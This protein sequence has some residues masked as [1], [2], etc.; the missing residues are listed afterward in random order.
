VLSEQFLE[1]L[2]FKSEIVEVA[3]S[4]VNLKQ[5]GRYRV[6]LCPFHNEKTPSFYIYPESESFYCFGCGAGGD[7]ITFIKKIESL[8][9]LDSVSFLAQR[10]GVP[11][12]SSGQDDSLIK[13]RETVFA[14]NRAAARFYHESLYSPIGEHAL[15]Y[16]KSRG[17]SSKTIRHFG[18]GFAPAEHFALTNHLLKEGFS[19]TVLIKANLVFAGKN[20]IW[21]RFRDRV[22]FP[23]IDLRGNVVAFG[24]R[25]ISE[26]LPKYLNTSETIVFKKNANLF[27][28]NFAKNYLSSASLILTEGYMDVIALYQAGFYNAVAT[29]GTA[30]TLNQAKLI[31]RYAKEVIICYDADTAGQKATARAISILKEAGLAIKVLTIS[32]GKD[33][34]EFIKAFGQE[35]KFRFKQ[36][37]DTSKNDVEYRLQKVSQMHDKNTVEGKISYLKE[38][39]KILSTLDNIEREIYASRLSEEM[40]VEKSTLIQQAERERRRLKKRSFERQIKDIQI[41]LSAKKDRANPEKAKFLRAANAE[42]A[43]I[44]YLIH[45]LDEIENI[46]ERL[47][48]EKFC[49]SFNRRLYENILAK[50]SKKQELR[51]GD[52]STEFSDNEMGKIAKFFIS[53]IP[54]IDTKES[55]KEYIDIIVLEKN[56]VEIQESSA[57]NLD[58]IMNYIEMLKSTKCGRN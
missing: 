50:A 12:P 1:E 45:H 48:P 34:D 28:L 38:A 10:A 31:A 27:A 41:N 30:L 13:M 51:V 17:L 4:Y 5:K 33:P 15:K 40:N 39:V 36:L 46:A 9:Y 22:I 29:L 3:P 21:D 11:I 55:L 52:F 24:G 43:L 44:A 56:R 6:G 58:G 49:T 47:P 32:H 7:V 35:G 26:K 37:I 8:S 42:E 18:L 25:S 19:K 54:R 16:L 53:E 57:Q 20:G 23:I 2:K 14:A